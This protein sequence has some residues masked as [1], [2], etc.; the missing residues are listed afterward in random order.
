MQATKNGSA[1]IDVEALYRRYGPMVL[2]RC[3]ALLGDEDR[4]LDAMQDVFVQ[5][6]RR[7]DRLNDRYPSSLLYRIATNT[8][9]NVL[10]TARRNRVLANE[11]IVNN[12]PGR[13]DPEQQTLEKIMLDQVF[14]GEK[15]STR[16]IAAMRY[17]EDLTW[18][19]T[20]QQSGLSISGARKRLESLQKR[21]LALLDS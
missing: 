8:S 21:G 16:R 3:R 12:A 9:L 5:L 10:R 13:F 11:E 15:E 7:K 2:R 20:S 19:E 6:L 17:V 4:A 18:E 1:G 14:A